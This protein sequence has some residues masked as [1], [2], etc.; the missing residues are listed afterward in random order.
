ME[1]REKYTKGNARR[2]QT[3]TD[4]KSM[5]VQRVTSRA[6]PEVIY[7]FWHVPFWWPISFCLSR[8]LARSPYL[9]S[10]DT[11]V[12]HLVV[13]KSLKHA[14]LTFSFPPFFPHC[15]F[16]TFYCY[17][18]F[19]LS[20]EDLMLSLSFFFSSSLVATS[21]FCKVWLACNA[22][23]KKILY[24]YYI[25][26]NRKTWSQYICLSVSLTAIQGRSLGKYL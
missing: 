14:W 3:R 4:S 6:Q 9:I 7:L 24:N 22:T 20:I 13:E 1:K 19:V 26:T 5:Y 2:L 18:C 10:L 16:L 23:F 12:R 15:M 11:K 17:M 8:S 21:G 25:I